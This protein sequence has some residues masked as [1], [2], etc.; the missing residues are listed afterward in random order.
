MARER[1]IHST[2]VLGV[3]KDGRA[4]MGGDGQV[5]TGNVIMKGTA[6]K[7]RKLGGGSVL[8]GFAGGLADALTLFERF[9][10]QLEAHARQLPRAAAELARAWRQDRYLR[11]LEAMI[12][13]MDKDHLLVISGQGDVVEPEDGVAAIGSGGNYAV[14]AAKAL[15]KHTDMSAEDIVKEAMAIT[16]NLCI[17]TNDHLTLETLGGDA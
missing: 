3:L 7:V 4:A 16:A 8:G 12:M 11:R 1:L 6:R 5:T 2:T 13:V 9:E 17:Y 15:L 10:D 14:A